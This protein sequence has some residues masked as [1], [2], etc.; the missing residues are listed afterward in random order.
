MAWY[1]PDGILLEV[2]EE[3]TEGDEQD[4]LEDTQ[5]GEEEAGR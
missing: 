2:L 3:G 4:N 5:Q 1:A